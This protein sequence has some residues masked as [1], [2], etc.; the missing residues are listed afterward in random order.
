MDA[1]YITIGFGGSGKS[2]KHRKSTLGGRN[3]DIIL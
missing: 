3:Q 1:A 2:G